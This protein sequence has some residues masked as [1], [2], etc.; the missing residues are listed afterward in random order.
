M[1]SLLHNISPELI[2]QAQL[3]NKDSLDQ[4]VEVVRVHLFGYIY[5][6]TLDYDLTQDLLQETILF[7]IQ[8]LNQLE[9]AEQFWHWMFRT[10]LGKVQHYNREMK[11]KK[12]V[13]LSE[14]EQM[15]IHHDVYADHNDGLTDLL[16]KE[17]SDAVF[18]A[19]RRLKL[20]YR[21]VLVL[22][23]FE[24][25]EYSEI[26]EVLNISET[27]SRVLFFRAKTSLRSQLATDGLG[28]RYFL[29]ALALFGLATNSTGAVSTTTITASTMQVGFVPTVLAWLSSKLGLVLIAETIAIGLALPFQMFLMAVGIATLVGLGIFAVCALGSYLFGSEG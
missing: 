2:H 6:L 26:A 15:R 8:S 4:I 16:R 10:A 19:M 18:R 3:G 21:N 7:M 13:E 12:A 28:S 25:L 22:R 27:Q 17:L 14:S 9:H 20:R 5:R 11:R 1:G 29:L 24:N 23:C